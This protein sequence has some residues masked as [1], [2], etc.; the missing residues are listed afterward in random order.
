MKRETRVDREQVSQKFKK[1]GYNLDT[2]LQL[3][4]ECDYIKQ[5]ANSM[6]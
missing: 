2:F 4:G 5:I 6:F 1:M 3:V